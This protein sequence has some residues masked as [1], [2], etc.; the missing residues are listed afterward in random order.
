MSY[1]GWDVHSYTAD[2]NVALRVWRRDHPRTSALLDRPIPKQVAAHIIQ[3][4][5]TADA[6]CAIVFHK[7]RERTVF[8]EPDGQWFYG[9][10]DLT[11]RSD[12]EGLNIWV[13]LAYAVRVVQH[14]DCDESTVH[15]LI[16]MILDAAQTCIQGDSHRI[17]MFVMAI[18][19]DGATALG[20][21]D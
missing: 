12:A 2:L 7:M 5:V 9:D 21:L 16:E 18:T 11:S 1:R 13:L 4:L 19:Q 6:R 8:S 3:F 20:T 17:A 14:E 15:L 10:K